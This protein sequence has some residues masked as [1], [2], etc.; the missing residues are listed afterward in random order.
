MQQEVGESDA[1]AEDD[2]LSTIEAVPPTPT[3]LRMLNMRRP[4]TPMS[5]TKQRGRRCSTIQKR[6]WAAVE[7]IGAS[8]AAT[9]KRLLLSSANFD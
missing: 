8:T 4:P 3:V 9:V 6:S 7:A 5:K 2:S 1:E